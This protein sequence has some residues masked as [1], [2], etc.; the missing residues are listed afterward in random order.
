[1]GQI[2]APAAGGVAQGRAL[3]TRLQ[4]GP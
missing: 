1:V 3:R 2:V 4:Y